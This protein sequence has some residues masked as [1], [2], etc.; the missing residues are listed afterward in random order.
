MT[1]WLEKYIKDTFDLNLMECNNWKLDSKKSETLL[2]FPETSI[3]DEHTYIKTV[4]YDKDYNKHYATLKGSINVDVKNAGFQNKEITFHSL[5]SGAMCS[6]ILTTA[7]E[8]ENIDFSRIL[9]ETA[10][11]GVWVAN[12]TAQL[13]YIKNTLKMNIMCNRIIDNSSFRQITT[14]SLF[15]SKV[16][17]NLTYD[18]TSKWKPLDHLEK[19]IKDLENAIRNAIQNLFNCSELQIRTHIIN[20]MSRTLYHDKALNN[21]ILNATQI[22]KIAE[23]IDRNMPGISKENKRN[24]EIGLINIELSNIINQSKE[25]YS[26]ILDKFTKI[27][28][29]HIIQND[30]TITKNNNTYNLIVGQVDYT[31]NNKMNKNF[32]SDVGDYIKNELQ[33]FW[34]NNNDIVQIYADNPDLKIPRGLVVKLYHDNSLDLFIKTTDLYKES[35]LIKP[36]LNKNILIQTHG[37]S[38]IIKYLISNKSPDLLTIFKKY[39]DDKHNSLINDYNS[40]IK[41]SPDRLASYKTKNS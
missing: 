20:Y 23:K 34:I 40:Y 9:E 7:I 39:C 21:N 38:E 27:I 10:L 31:H 41:L 8:S 24:A 29:D 3:K 32:R 26:M 22:E 1:Y 13:G 36:K 30:A 11:I 12:S 14:K 2:W 15:T 35:I 28:K 16:F 5:R 18:L 4:H 33:P 25:N 37:T 6:R 19:F 17:H